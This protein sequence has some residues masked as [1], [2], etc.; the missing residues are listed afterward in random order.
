MFWINR[1]QDVHL[2]EDM[3]GV[4]SY[5]ADE[6]GCSSREVFLIL[7]CNIITKQKQ[8]KKCNNKC[9]NDNADD[10]DNW[11]FSFWVTDLAMLGD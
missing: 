10:D 8:R 11:P 4:C 9:N 2:A 5:G 6:L 3:N 1:L 7:V